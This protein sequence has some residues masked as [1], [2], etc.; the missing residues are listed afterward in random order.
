MATVP[1]ALLAGLSTPYARRGELFKAWERYHGR[2]DPDTLVWVAPSL[3]MNPSLDPGVIER[4]YA[5]DPLAAAAEFGAEWRKDVEPFLSAEAVEACRVPGRLE[6]APFAPGPARDRDPR[7]GRAPVYVAF[8]DP[9]G[10]SQDSMT[11]AVAHAE[12]ERAVLDLVREV[13]PPFSPDTV[14]TE[15]AAVL[16]SYGLVE[17]E[18]DAYAG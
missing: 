11:L 3:V 9:S 6:L 7:R 8:T 18:G 13:R 14:V 10:G 2:D 4:A 1:G 12:G 16:K 5:D 17:V 15:F